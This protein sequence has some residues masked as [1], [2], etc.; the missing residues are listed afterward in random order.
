MYRGGFLTLISL[1]KQPLTGANQERSD[2]FE[3]KAQYGALVTYITYTRWIALHLFEQRTATALKE[4]H[5][6]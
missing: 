4:S 1:Q 6:A 3:F 2:A 5:S